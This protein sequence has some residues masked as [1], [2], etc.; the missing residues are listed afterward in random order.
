LR[1][2]Q[3]APMSVL[4]GGVFAGEVDDNFSDLRRLVDDVGGRAADA[5][6]GRRRLPEVFDETAWRNLEETGL[7]RLTTNP[8]LEAGPTEAAVVLRGLARHAVAAP[9]AETDLL[10]AWLAG[11]TGVEVP[12]SGPLTV[13]LADGTHDGARIAG[14]AAA[15]PWTRAAERVLLAVRVGGALHVGAADPGALAIRDGYNLAGEP[16]DAVAFDLPSADFAEADAALVDQLTRRGAWARCVQC[17]GALDAAAQLSVAHTRE[18]VQFGRPLSSFQAVQHTLAQMAGEIERARATTELATAAVA[19]HGFA[20]GQAHYAVA[21]AKV[22][23]GRVVPAVATA[24]HQLHGAIGV[25]IE[26]PLWSSTNRAYS[27]IGEF[28]STGQHARYL[29]RLALE[30]GADA[31]TLW[32]VLTGG[33]GEAGTPG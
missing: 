23:L 18:R 13:A 12:P 11:Q 6:M 5:R 14:T 29:G 31:G 30:H 25:T 20:S 17:I 28:G 3:K 32:D 24:A 7:S 19:D 27:W 2:E 33:A 15:V 16:R 26:H 4:A 8:D 22:V 9:V 1:E 21:V 10:G